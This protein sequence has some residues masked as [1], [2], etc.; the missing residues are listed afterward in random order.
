MVIYGLVIV[1]VNHR[2]TNVPNIIAERY[3]YVRDGLS[4]RMVIFK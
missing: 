2:H 1:S 3:A 4:T